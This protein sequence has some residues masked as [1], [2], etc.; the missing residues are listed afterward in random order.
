MNAVSSIVIDFNKEKNVFKGNHQVILDRIYQTELTGRKAWHFCH[1]AGSGEEYKEHYFQQHAVVI[2]LQPELNSL[3]RL[4]DRIE[5]E[6]VKIGDVAIIPASVNHWQ[7]FKTELLIE[8]FVITLEPQYLSKLAYESINSDL[9]ELLPTFNKTDWL[10]QGIALNLKN[11]LESDNYDKLYAE[12][13][14][15]TLHLHLLKHYLTRKFELKEYRD[16]LPRYKLR[17]ALDYIHSHLDEKI[18]LEEIAR[19]LNI[20]QYYFCRL[21]RQSMGISPYQYVIEQRIQKAKVL[22]K[23]NKLSLAEIALE[24]GFS[25]QSQMTRHFSQKMGI[26]PRVYRNTSTM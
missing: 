24:C 6:N 18:E 3:R 10:I 21:F 19:L 8:G 15:N 7:K 16:G 26:T 11:E 14:Y 20:S 4:G 1:K 25:N 2:Y 5:R 23:Q 17:Q 22:L 13:L 12:A 9:I